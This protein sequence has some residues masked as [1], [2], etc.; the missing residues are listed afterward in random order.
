LTSSFS[1]KFF[2]ETIPEW[3]LRLLTKYKIGYD[4]SLLQKVKTGESRPARRH[5]FA[6]QQK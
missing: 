3:R 2:A 6:R 5:T 4:L 1:Y